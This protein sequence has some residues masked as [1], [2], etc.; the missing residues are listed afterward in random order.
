[1]NF[2]F[3]V[4]LGVYMALFSVTASSS[5]IEIPHLD[6][7]NAQSGE[8]VYA[9]G[10]ISNQSESGIKFKSASTSCGCISVNM[11]PGVCPP[12]QSKEFSVRI[13]TA[14]KVGETTQTL[15]FT[16]NTGM[17]YSTISIKVLTD[18]QSAP[19]FVSFRYPEVQQKVQKIQ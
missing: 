10:T 12:G 13:D 17:F 19:A 2:M 14:G 8:I 16:T 3:V 9:T 4:P 11:M 7:G 18:I 5:L 1:M 15:S 6:F